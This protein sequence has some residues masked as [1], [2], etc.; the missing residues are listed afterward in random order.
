MAVINIEQGLVT[1]P[2]VVAGEH[3][4]Q[5]QFFYLHKYREA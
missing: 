2:A 5:L 3:L 4:R 1:H